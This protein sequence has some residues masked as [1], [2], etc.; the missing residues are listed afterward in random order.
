[1]H[2]DLWTDCY[3]IINENTQQSPSMQKKKEKLPI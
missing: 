2:I 3:Q 1:M